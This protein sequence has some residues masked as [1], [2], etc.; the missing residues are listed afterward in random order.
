MRSDNQPHRF[1][2]GVDLHT[3]SLYAHVL[4]GRHPAGIEPA[5]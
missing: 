2:C 4:D 1:Y 5:L 3:R